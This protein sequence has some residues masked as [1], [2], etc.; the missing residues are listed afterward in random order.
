MENINY[1]YGKTTDGHNITLD[2]FRVESFETFINEKGDDCVRLYFKSGKEISVLQEDDELGD[3]MEQLCEFFNTD[4]HVEPFKHHPES[5]ICNKPNG[6][7]FSFDGLAIEY[8]V[9]YKN[10][11][12][13]DVVDLHFVSGRTV[14][15]LMDLD[16]NIYPGEN[17]ITLVDQCICRYKRIDI[18]DDDDEC[19]DS[20]RRKYVF[21]T[22]VFATVGRIR[23]DLEE[24]VKLAPNSYLSYRDEVNN[25]CYISGIKEWKDLVLLTTTVDED[26][27]ME[28]QDLLNAWLVDLSD[29]TEVLLQHG[30]ELRNLRPDLRNDRFFWY[31]EDVECN[32]FEI[33]PSDIRLV[34]GDE[35]MC[36]AEDR[37]EEEPEKRL[38]C[39]GEDGKVYRV[40]ELYDDDGLNYIRITDG[41]EGEDVHVSDLDGCFYFEDGGVVVIRNQKGT[42]T[43]YAISEVESSPDSLPVFFFSDKVGEED[44]VAFRLGNVVYRNDEYDIDDED[45]FS[46]DDI[47]IRPE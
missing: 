18:D 9:S 40:I 12:G 10:A 1:I 26:D 33:V 21:L 17:V 34:S 42:I 15:V 19:D 45:L 5:I 4:F 35:L 37:V 31:D 13:N 20:C 24:I 27:A 3:F 6:D 14:T 16:E 2:G 29:D 38:V 11:E 8:H 43:Y 22:N 39:L 32:C 30:W 44:V 46:D 28:V 41:D 25:D 36:E 47:V 23:K 7:D